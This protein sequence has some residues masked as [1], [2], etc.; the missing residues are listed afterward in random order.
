MCVTFH[1]QEQA[2]ETWSRTHPQGFV[3]NQFGGGNPTYNKLQSNVN[4]SAL[5]RASDAGSPTVCP[6]VCCDSLACIEAT[7]DQL[8]GGRHNWE[9]CGLP[10]G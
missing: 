1:H 9:R 4:C 6:K 7:A 10:N 8:R 3:F 2:Y 5:T